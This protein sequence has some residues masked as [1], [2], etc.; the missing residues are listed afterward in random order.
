MRKTVKKDFD[1]ST[2]VRVKASAINRILLKALGA[3][4]GAM[5]KGFEIDYPSYMIIRYAPKI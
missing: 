4:R 1:G 2:V 5:L 3:P